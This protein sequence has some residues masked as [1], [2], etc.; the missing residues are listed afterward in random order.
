MTVKGFRLTVSMPPESV[1]DITAAVQDQVHISGI[2]EGFVVLF[3][4]GSTT[5]LSTM[6]FEPGLRKDIFDAM[7]RVAPREVDYAHHATWHDDNGRS[8][9]RATVVGPSLVVPVTNGRL[10]LGPWQQ[11][12][13]FNFDIRSRNREV[14]GKVIGV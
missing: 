14:V 1:Q 3:A 8:H 6:E 11:I 10:D 4:R 13:L 5:A 12:V 2:R 7:E 9:V